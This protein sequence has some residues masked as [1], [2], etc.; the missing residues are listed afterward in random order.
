MARAIFVSILLA[1]AALSTS[2]QEAPLP[3]AARG[4][5]L[6]LDQAVAYAQ[7]HNRQVL[8]VAKEVEKANDQ[9]LATKS[10]RL[11]QF[12]VVAHGSELLTPISFDFPAGIFETGSGQPVPAENTTI[13]TPRRP[14]A[15]VIGKMVEPLSQQYAIHLGIEAQEVGVKL[16]R[17]N[18]RLQ[19]ETL[20]ASVKDAYYGLLQTQS[21]EEASAENVKWLEELDRTTDAYVAEKTALPYQSMGV[22]AQLAQARAQFITLED[23]YDTQKE[24]LND[25]MGRDILTDFSVS[26]VPETLPE[27]GDLE[28]ARSEALANRPEI[29]QGKLK[30]D[31][32]ELDVRSEKAAYIP[33]VSFAV[34]YVSPFNVRFVPS[35]IASAGIMVEWD[36]FDWGYKRHLLDQKKRTVDESRLNLDETESQVVIDVDN[37]FRKLREARA[38]LDAARLSHDAEQEKLRVVLEEYKQKATLLSTALQEQATAT[39]VSSAYQQALAA[40]WT[41]RADFEK[42]LGE[43]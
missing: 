36:I 25:L 38:N 34:N 23:T 37:R 4:P 13:T 18:L 39:Q 12:D 9:V 29:H 16:E 35:N 26:E 42:S 21:A 40:F 28:A 19:R 24:N 32:A 2:A 6:T 41:A 33:E 27:E 8:I 11:P 17:E 14:T 31:Q 30:I 22:K 7:T 3:T 43:D 5:T 1:L 10:Q 15:F 20:T